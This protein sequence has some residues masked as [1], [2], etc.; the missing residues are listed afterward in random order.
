[1][2][3]KLLSLFILLSALCQGQ[4]KWDL[5]TC[6]SYALNHNISL[7]QNVLNNEINKNNADQSKLAVLP[8]LNAGFNH[9]YN[10]GQ[11]IDRYTN[12][13]ADQRVLSQNLYANASVV[14]WSGL[15]QYNNIKANEYS[16]LSGVERIKQSENDISL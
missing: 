10:F 11:T 8:S 7:R 15:S 3:T 5:Q 9:V 4:S 6:I 16:Y 12:Q 1:M 13:F 2:K 14:L